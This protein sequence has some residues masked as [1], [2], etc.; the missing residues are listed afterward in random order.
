MPYQLQESHG[1]SRLLI[2]PR[3]SLSCSDPRCCTNTMSG[4]QITCETA[5]P[6]ETGRRLQ[7]G[8]WA[9]ASARVAASLVVGPRPRT[10][11]GTEDCEARERRACCPGWGPEAA[12]GPSRKGRSRNASLRHHLHRKERGRWKVRRC[13]RQDIEWRFRRPKRGP[14]LI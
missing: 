9:S 4:L 10:G 14:G 3:L 8:V 5:N 7:V 12:V 11:L 13:N 2:F 6:G 1:G